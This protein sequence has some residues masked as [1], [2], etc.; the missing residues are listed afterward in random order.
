MSWEGVQILLVIKRLLN[1]P[2]EVDCVVTCLS[3]ESPKGNYNY[4][5]YNS[6]III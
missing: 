3:L 1:Y 2:Q 5:V 6:N 4:A